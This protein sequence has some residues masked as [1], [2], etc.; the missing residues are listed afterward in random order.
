[1]RNNVEPKPHLDAVSLAEMLSEDVLEHML[2]C[3]ECLT[4][5][6]KQSGMYCSLFLFQ[7]SI[8]HEVSGKAKSASS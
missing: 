3:T 6:V 1:M 7:A 5:P 4:G 8:R 2:V